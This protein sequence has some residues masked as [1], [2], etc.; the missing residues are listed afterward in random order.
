MSGGGGLTPGARGAGGNSG[1]DGSVASITAKLQ[2]K[3]EAAA[4]SADPSAYTTEDGQRVS[5]NYYTIYMHLYFR[6]NWLDEADITRRTPGKIP[7]L[8][9]TNPKRAERPYTIFSARLD[10]YAV[11]T[12]GRFHRAGNR[13]LSCVSGYVRSES[14]CRLRSLALRSDRDAELYRQ[15][16]IWNRRKKPS[17]PIQNRTGRSASRPALAAASLAFPAES[18]GYR[19]QV[20][21]ALPGSARRTH[22]SSLEE[23]D[24]AQTKS[25]HDKLKE[26][27]F[28]ANNEYDTTKRPGTGDVEIGAP[29]GDFS[30]DSAKKALERARDMSDPFG[31]DSEASKIR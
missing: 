10:L 24:R 11:A 2:A 7:C 16:R 29:T 14:R 27:N 12:G 22:E 23:S 8:R 13:A 4:H 25:L 19:S 1:M 21:F 6:I 20:R 17:R 15:G 18:S 28:D 30:D 31:D 5:R 3:S 9:Q 26:L